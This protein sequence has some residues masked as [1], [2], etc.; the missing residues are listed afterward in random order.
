MTASCFFSLNGQNLSA[1]VC[2][3]LGSMPAFSGG[4]AYLNDPAKVAVVNNG[5]LP[6]GRYYIVSRQSGGKLGWLRELI[7][8]RASG[9]GRSEW[10]ALYRIDG[11]I[12]DFTF[13]EGVRRGNFRLHPIGRRGISEGCITLLSLTQFNRLR[14]HLLSQESKLIPGT[15]IKYFGTVDVR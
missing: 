2:A 3:G 13:V 15:N 4:P 14:T 11:K 1:L 5:P 12:D 6:A 7:A 10:F 8:E 9:A